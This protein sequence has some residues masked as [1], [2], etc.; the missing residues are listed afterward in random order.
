MRRGSGKPAGTTRNPAALLDKP[1]DLAQ[2][3][4]HEGKR[5]A[6]C[7]AKCKAAF[8]KD[9]KKYADKLPK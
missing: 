3:I 5:I 7:C 1:I 9:P 4:E 2:T 8:Q 6:F